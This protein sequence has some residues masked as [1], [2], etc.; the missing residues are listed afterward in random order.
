M[1][2]KRLFLGFAIFAT[3]QVNAQNY[4]INFAGTGASKTVSE[5]KVENLTEG[6][7]LILHKSEILRLIGYFGVSSLDNISYSIRIYPNP[8]TTNNAVSVSYTHLTLPT[9]RIV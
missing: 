8:M 9:K 2:M 1:E 5:V 3:L 4:L 6:T 7:S